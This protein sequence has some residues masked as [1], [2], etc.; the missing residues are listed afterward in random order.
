MSRTVPSSTVQP[1]PRLDRDRRLL[2]GGLL[3]GVGAWLASLAGRLSVTRAT[4][5]DSIVIGNAG[6]TGQSL[7]S[8]SA[9]LAD[10]PA[11]RGLN[12]HASGRG[13]QGSATSGS[14]ISTGVWGQS[15]STSGRGVVGI[16]TGTA[17]PSDGI[18]VYGEARGTKSRGISGKATSASGMTVGVEGIALSTS[19]V[20]VAG[21]ATAATGTTFGVSGTVASSSGIA[22]AGEATAATNGTGVRGVAGGAGGTGVVG[23]SSSGTGDG[24][25]VIGVAFSPEGVGVAGSSTSAIGVMGLSTDSGLA[26]VHPPKT[27]IYGYG[28]HDA[29]SRGVHGHSPQGRGVFGQSESGSGGFFSATT[30]IALRTSGRLRFEKASGTATIASAT[31]SVEVT[32]GLN[33]GSGTF[34]L[35]SPRGNLGGRDLWHSVDAAADTFTIH[36]SSNVAA[37]LVVGWLVVN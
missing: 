14:G 23:F 32:P 35:L 34:V 19:G 6:Q 24:I 22:L 16:T 29:T 1:E 12:S 3:G 7:T 9:G 30:G 37:D 15:A 5:G 31:N 36:T 11:F 13:L 25:G 28:H 20:G 33:L 26:P 21:R 17:S 27:A 18:G 2:L 4:D 10:T 8:L